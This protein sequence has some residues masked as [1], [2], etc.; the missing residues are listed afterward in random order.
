[1]KLLRAFKDILYSIYK[2]KT[3]IKKYQLHAVGM[4]AVGS[5]LRRCC[6][7]KREPKLEES[8]PLERAKHFLQ[9]SVVS[10]A[11]FTVATNSHTVVVVYRF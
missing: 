3:N 2:E 5:V 1:M 4:K 9:G 8:V 10:H 7:Y 6:S 11:L